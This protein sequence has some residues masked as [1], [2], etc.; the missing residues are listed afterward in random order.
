ME[1][2]RKYDDK[3]IDFKSPLSLKTVRNHNN[4]ILKVIEK[5]NNDENNKNNNNDDNNNYEKEKEKEIDK[6][7]DKF[8]DN[9]LDCSVDCLHS[10]SEKIVKNYSPE[11]TKRKNENLRKFSCP[12]VCSLKTI[13]QSIKDQQYLL[14]IRN[15]LSTSIIPNY[16]NNDNN[17]NGNNGNNDDLL[18]NHKLVILCTSALKECCSIN[19]SKNND[20]SNNN[21]DN[22]NSNINITNDGNAI[23]TK[24]LI[25]MSVAFTGGIILNTRNGRNNIINTD[26]HNNNNNINHVNNNNNNINNSNNISNSFGNVST[27]TEIDTSHNNESSRGHYSNNNLYN[28]GNNNNIIN[29]NNATLNRNN[30]DVFNLYIT[31]IKTEINDN[32]WDSYHFLSKVLYTQVI[33]IENKQPTVII[34]KKLDNLDN[35][36]IVINNT[37]NEEINKEDNNENSNHE[38]ESSNNDD[39]NNDNDNK[40]DNKNEI[41]N[42]NI[43]RQSIKDIIY[44]KKKLLNCCSTSSK[45][46]INSSLKTKNISLEKDLDQIESQYGEITPII[47]NYNNINI[48]NNNNNNNN[49]SN[50]NENTEIKDSISVITRLFFDFIDSRL[51]SIFDDLMI[52]KLSE[53]WKN[54]E[55]S[56]DTEDFFHNN[57]TGKNE[58]KSRRQDDN[59]INNHYI[60]NKEDGLDTIYLNINN[61]FESNKLDR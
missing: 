10:T 35:K 44:D 7:K 8:K 23:N 60:N 46:T 12:A 39:G 27:M 15:S 36:E 24:N 18:W 31:S 37:H 2:M 6:D 26:S 43:S 22:G 29:I 57:L 9:S 32:D 40:Y 19:Y 4:Q 45:S 13:S 42:E 25:D 51:D 38:S 54:D 61:L 14:S 21:I 47:C 5:E 33:H 30:I 56:D 11:F 1:P 41:E 34:T 3:L 17:N 50:T 53:I 59:I 28:H 48:N 16:N 20:D 49:N 52:E 58:F 55:N